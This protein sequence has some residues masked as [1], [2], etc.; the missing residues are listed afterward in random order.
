MSDQETI[1]ILQEM[2]EELIK[3]C[4]YES[5]EKSVLRV[6]ALRKAH[7]FMSHKGEN[8]GIY[9]VESVKKLEE[10]GKC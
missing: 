9:T 2:I 6:K 7:Y 5:D 8:D 1:D 10:L 4:R 3:K